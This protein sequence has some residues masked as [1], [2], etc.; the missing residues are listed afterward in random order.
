M[1]T[2]I[3]LLFSCLDLDRKH[4][5]R[6]LL[7]QMKEQGLRLKFLLYCRLDNSLHSSPQIPKSSCLSCCCLHVGHDVHPYACYCGESWL[8]HKV[9]QYPV[10]HKSELSNGRL[11]LG[12]SS[13][14]QNK[15][16]SPHKTQTIK[17]S[18]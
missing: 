2:H 17:Y 6:K 11:T 4:L 5:G 18:L 10:F 14:S 8:L 13:V 1:H 9:T 16:S 15:T 3:L 7:T 12:F